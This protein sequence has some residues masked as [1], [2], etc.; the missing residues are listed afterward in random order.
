MSVYLGVGGRRLSEKLALL[1]GNP[2]RGEILPFVPEDANIDEEEIE[3]ALEVL[4]SKKLSQLASAKVGE[5]EEA[6]AEYYGVK[7]A[8]AVSSGTTALHVALAAMGLGAGDGVILP[9]Y[10]F[11]ATANAILHQNAVPV[12]ADI[13]PKTYNI[14]SESIRNV[15]TRKTKAIIPV[16]MLGH[17]ADMDSILEAAKEKDLIVIE[18][19]AQA[20]GAEY[21]GRKVGTFGTFGCF[22][23]YLNKNI[24]SGGEGGMVITNDDDLAEKAWSIANHCRVKVSPY[25]NVPAHNV[26]WGIG[27]NYRMTAFQAAVGLTQLKKLDKFNE[28]RRKNA[29]YLTKEIK[30]I[31]GLEPPYVSP[32]VNHVYWAYGVRVI[33][34]KLGISRDQFAKALLAEGI[35][36][37]GYAPIP[38]HLQKVIREKV[39]YGKFH[40]PFDCP[41]YGEKPKYMEGM[42]PKA[43]RLCNED[44]LLPVYP[45]L[46]KQDL[47][48]VSKALAKVAA[49]KEELISF[50]KSIK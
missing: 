29:E 27:Y 5:F 8:I 45:T 19:C 43:E 25:P 44:L 22:S 35:R 41:F 32:N 31:D 17:P 47:E 21:K 36:A 30:K 20:N 9:P 50:F 2:V 12:F 38:V 18:D 6:F 16:H 42:C 40:C 4:R 33:S 7:H 24:T 14:D 46:S 3:A 1:G 26:Y 13:D 15:A 49:H 28:V 34:E 11:M 23:F 37:E 10:T 48:D 39:G